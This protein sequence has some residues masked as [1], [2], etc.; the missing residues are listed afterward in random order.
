MNRL[1]GRFD[2]VYDEWLYPVFE[3]LGLA[4]PRTIWLRRI[5]TAGNIRFVVNTSDDPHL[6]GIAQTLPALGYV[7]KYHV[8]P[9]YAWENRV[10]RERRRSDRDSGP[11]ATGR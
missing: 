8:G 11:Q 7:R 3:A 9:F 2:L 10:F 5:L 4:E 1:H 6:D